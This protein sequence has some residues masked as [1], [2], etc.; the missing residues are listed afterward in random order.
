MVVDHVVH[1]D[2]VGV[3]DPG[4]AAGLAAGALV[5]R[6]ELVVVQVRRDV[7]LLQRDLT[8]EQLVLG[9]PDRAHAAAAYA[10]DEAVPPGDQ[11]AVVLPLTGRR[12]PGH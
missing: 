3:G 6:G 4:G 12:L 8:V 1:D 10:V 7:Q 2:D 11:P 9:A 5:E